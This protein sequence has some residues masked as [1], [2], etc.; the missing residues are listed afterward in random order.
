[1]SLPIA[2]N[3]AVMKRHKRR[4]KALGQF[5]TGLSLGRYRLVLLR[6]GGKG[7]ATPANRAFLI[8]FPVVETRMIYPQR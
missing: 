2:C 1:M 8:Q 7:T 5:I 6:V 4:N 3:K